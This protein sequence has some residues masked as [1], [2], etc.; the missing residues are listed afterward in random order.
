[1]CEC[2]RVGKIF[3]GEK[4]YLM[5]FRNDVVEFLR[6]EGYEV[7]QESISI[8][9]SY[10]ESD[11]YGLLQNFLVVTFPHMSFDHQDEFI[12]EFYYINYRSVDGQLVFTEYFYDILA[13]HWLR[14]RDYL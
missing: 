6:A 12:E 7:V 5:S 8:R 11:G 10:L 9:W 13:A 3:G 2:R 4:V 14:E 1:M